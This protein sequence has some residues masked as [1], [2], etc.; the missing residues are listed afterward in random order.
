MSLI[1]VLP[2]SVPQQGTEHTALSYA[3]TAPRHLVHR[4]AVAEVLLTDWRQLGEDSFRL[5]AQ[6][7]RGHS[8]YGP[9]ARAWHDP[10]LVAE[11]VRQ[12][13]VLLG[14][15]FYGVPAGHPS[16]MSALDFQTA[17]R[18][19]AVGPGPADVELR[20]ECRDVQRRGRHLAAMCLDATLLR[21]GRLMGTGRMPL[22]IMSPAV[23]RRLRGPY[24]TPPDELPPRPAPVPPGQVGRRDPRDVVLG[25]P[26]EERPVGADGLNG[27]WA[28][29]SWQLRI[30]RGHPVL[31]DH[32]VDHVPG[33]ALLEAARQAAQALSPAQVLP[34]AVDSKYYRY[35][36]LAAP[37]W[38][39]A[40]RT[41]IRRGKDAQVRVRAE[42]NGETVFES[43]VSAELCG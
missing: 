22:Q 28:Y 18:P 39:T 33:M 30:D 32:P 14:H 37:C 15:E 29:G 8:F 38:V 27:D 25:T 31:F 11:T 40:T 5:A 23:Y 24:A 4:A 10:L 35:V 43:T 20:I 12:A 41:P 42:Q 16:L 21:D 2:A 34:V 3:R 26:G 19:L 13:S 9:V 7:P 1:D 36:E 6:W 17:P